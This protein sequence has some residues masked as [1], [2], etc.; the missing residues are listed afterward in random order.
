MLYCII[1]HNSCRS[2]Q[3]GSPTSYDFKFDFAI[4]PALPMKGKGPKVWFKT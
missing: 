1:Y 4:L 3:Y 2:L